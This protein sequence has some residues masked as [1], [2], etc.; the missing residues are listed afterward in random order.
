MKGLVPQLRNMSMISKLFLILAVT[1]LTQTVNADW[2]RQES[3]S[4][5][6]FRDVYFLDH[7]KGWIVGSD[8]VMLTTEDGGTTWTYRKKFTT[9]TL[10]Q[11]YFEN[12]SKGWLLC[13]RNIYAR[14]NDPMSY[15]LRTEDGGESWNKVEFPD[16]GRER[17]TRLLFHNDGRATAFGEGGVFYGLKAETA[18][19]KKSQ[20]G[21]RYLL[22]DGAYSN[23]RNGAIVGAAGTI[24]FTD[25]GGLSWAK[26]TLLGDLDTRFNA[27]DFALKA[28][29]A[30]GSKGRIFR[31]VGVRLWRQVDSGVSVDL[32][33]V[34]FINPTDGWAV[35]D[36]GVIIRSN[37]S[38][39]TWTDGGSKTTHRLERVVFSNG[40]GWAV[41]HGGTVLTYDEAGPGHPSGPK[42]VLMRKS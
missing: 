25:D 37:D 18:Q 36:N 24:L 8:G 9:D 23:N 21:L 29:W 5:A 11:I 4:L 2:V 22:L 38:G 15:L 7:K 20:T 40:R 19:W 13:Q 16:A 17:M 31:S 32:N 1:F 42:P 3:N 28:G 26:A 35:G 34:Y 33:D 41:G 12:R 27:V 14:G 39:L 10:L 6:W 30:V